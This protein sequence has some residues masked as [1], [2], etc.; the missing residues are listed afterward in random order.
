[1]KHFVAFFAASVAVEILLIKKNARVLTLNVLLSIFTLLN[2][3]THIRFKK[4]QIKFL[5]LTKIFIDQYLSI[6]QRNYFL[7]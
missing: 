7:N 6:E 4:I 2:G 5:I 1:M 3:T